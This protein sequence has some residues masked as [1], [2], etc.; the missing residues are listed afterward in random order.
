MGQHR[1]ELPKGVRT[2]IWLMELLKPRGKVCL[3]LGCGRGRFLRR[4][5]TEGAKTVI[6]VDLNRENLKH[7]HATTEA[8]LLR[9]DIEK[10]ALRSGTIDVL[11]CVATI[12]HLPNPK[13]AVREMSRVVKTRNGLIF[14]SW[15][16]YRWIRAFRSRHIAYRLVLT[17]RDAMCRLIPA[18]KGE[19]LPE[20]CLDSET[21]GSTATAAFLTGQ[22]QTFWT[23]QIWL[24]FS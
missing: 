12:E 20:I 21:T 5:A 6:G 14:I 3:S 22:S 11:E 7:C 17:I 8:E 19:T 18:P 1:R 10:L 16:Y 13:E 4:Y 24:R 15:N 23:R 2:R 9:C